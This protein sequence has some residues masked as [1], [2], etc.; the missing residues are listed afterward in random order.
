MA[1]SAVQEAANAA[2]GRGEWEQAHARF[3]EALTLRRSGE[4]L[5]GMGRALSWLKAPDAALEMRTQAYAAF[6]R[7]GRRPDALRNAVWLAREYRSVRRNEAAA[8]GW[9]SRAQTVAGPLGEIRGTGWLRLAESE[10]PG[11]SVETALRLSAGAVAAGREEEDADLEIAALAR[12]GVL[13]VTWGHVLA[14][15][16]HVDEALAAATGGEARDPEYVGEAFCALLEVAVLLGDMHQVNQW[17]STLSEFRERYDY[18]PLAAHGGTS[19]SQ[20][21][22]TYCGSCC[23]A[24]YLVTGRLDEAEEQLSTTVAELEAEGLHSRCVHPVTQLAELRIAQGRLESAESLLA[25]Y[26]E[27]PECTRA[28]VALDL[29]LRRTDAALLRLRAGLERLSDQPLP[30]LPLWSQMVDAELSAGDVAAAEAAAG[31]VAR[32]AELTG[33]RLHGTEALFAR[34]KVAAARGDPLALTFLR[35]AARAFGDL[36]MPLSACRARLAYA[37][38][39][40]ESD[41]GLA[42]AEA[43]ASL[44]ALERLGAGLDADAAAALLRSLGVRGRTG[45]KRPS[46]LSRREQEVLVLLSRGLSN[47]EIAERLFISPKT[48]GHHVSSI[49]TKLGV[50]SRTEAAA[51]AVIHTQK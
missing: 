36:S 43:R 2:L 15:L 41:R 49:L 45:P 13:E 31:E 16:A 8:R 34:G 23:G 9:L 17:A 20:L 35:D 42:V 33:S 18:A 1:G 28:L 24:V 32:V 44:T 38:A 40:A 30:G 46:A 5:E 7:E 29:A 4:A 47:A 12:C 21:L 37:R 39:A 50:R 19:V 25:R 48:A 6:L 10:E 14:G 26:E 11:L 27:L 22:S 3:A 51:Y